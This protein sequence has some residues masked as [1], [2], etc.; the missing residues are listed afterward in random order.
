MS[1]RLTEAEFELLQKRQAPARKQSRSRGAV[2][3][4]RDGMTFDSKLESQHHYELQMEERAGKISGLRHHVL[5]PIVVNEVLICQYEA[6]H[7]YVRDG[8]RIV[9]DSKGYTTE[10]YRLKK[11]LMAAVNGI[12]IVEVRK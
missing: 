12:A 8:Q 11:K 10:V 4:T 9:E 3:V 7:V 6:D 1:L 5:F 2:K